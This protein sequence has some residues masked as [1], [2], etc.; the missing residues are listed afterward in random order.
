VRP[1]CGAVTFV[2][3]FGG[4]LNLNVHFHVV[5]LDGTFTRDA[6]A[7]VHFHEAEAPIEGEHLALATPTYTRAMRWLRRHGHLADCSREAHGNNGDLEAAMT[8]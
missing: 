4:S 5:L 6:G 7:R 8:P 3:R 2:Q 1:Q